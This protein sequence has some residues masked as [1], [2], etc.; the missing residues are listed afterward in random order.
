VAGREKGVVWGVKFNGTAVQKS[1]GANSGQGKKRFATKADGPQG[2]K[3]GVVH[4]ETGEI[5]K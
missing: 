4:F 2:K 5:G 3:G 1:E